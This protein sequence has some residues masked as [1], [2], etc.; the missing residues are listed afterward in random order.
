MYRF[1]MSGFVC[2]AG[3]RNV[4]HLTRWTVSCGLAAGSSQRP[5]ALYV[6]RVSKAVVFLFFVPA[7]CNMDVD[8]LSGA[9]RG[10]Q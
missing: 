8:V 10:R 4:C 1:V 2:I 7:F 9:F 6:W 3:S 5:S